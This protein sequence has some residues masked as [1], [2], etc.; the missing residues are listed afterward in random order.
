MKSSY[1]CLHVCCYHV[2]RFDF[3]IENLF[4]WCME[5]GEWLSFKFWDALSRLEIGILKWYVIMLMD[6][7]S[8][9]CFVCPWTLYNIP[10][11]VAVV[12]YWNSDTMV[13]VCWIVLYNEIQV[14]IFTL[15]CY[16]GWL[17][18]YKVAANGTVVWFQV[19]SIR[20]LFYISFPFIK[21]KRYHINVVLAP[22][23]GLPCTT[24]DNELIDVAHFF[25]GSNF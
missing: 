4:S 7:H 15:F 24:A 20:L 23:I 1:V 22:F 2:V 13:N 18:Y 5:F 11:S 21:I 14:L 3:F 10:L 16:W 12:L 17:R 25:A 9:V 6:A 8:C 19:G